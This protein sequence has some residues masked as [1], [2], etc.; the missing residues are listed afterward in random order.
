MPDLF[1]V[2]FIDAVRDIEVLESLTDGEE[3]RSIDLND[4]YLIG[5]L[6]TIGEGLAV[7]ELNWLLEVIAGQSLNHISDS[8]RGDDRLGEVV[9]VQ[10]SLLLIHFFVF[11]VYWK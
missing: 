4:A 9:E 10:V 7:S 6:E 11:L 5:R 8:D 2:L 1:I 3:L